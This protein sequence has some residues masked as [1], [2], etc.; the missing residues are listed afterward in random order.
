MERRV[1][2]LCEEKVRRENNGKNKVDLKYYLE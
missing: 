1:E 2:I